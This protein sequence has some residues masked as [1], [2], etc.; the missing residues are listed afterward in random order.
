MPLHPPEPFRIKMVEPINLI[1]KEERKAALKRA[2]Y[3][4]FALQA[5]EIFVDL[6]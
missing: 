2:G 1:S 4:P 6:Q 5:D 3:N